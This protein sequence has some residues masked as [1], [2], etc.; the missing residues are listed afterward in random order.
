MGAIVLAAAG[1]LLTEVGPWYRA[2]RKSRINPPDWAFGPVW[3]LILG[4]A[5]ASAALAWT[6]APDAAGRTEVVILFLVNALF[7]FLWSPL[8][9]KL[10]RPDWAFYEM[11]FLWASILAMII[12][13]APFSALAAWLLVPY[14]LWVSVAGWLNFAIVRLNGPF[15]TR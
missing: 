5:A 3:T 8:F 6:G 4:M 7:H 14:I 11:V 12:G 1:G 13:V 10:K 9:F 15:P 2:L